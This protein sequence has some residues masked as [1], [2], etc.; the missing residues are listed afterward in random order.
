[1]G[2]LQRPQ[3]LT[4]GRPQVEEVPHF[5][6]PGPRGRP[7]HPERSIPRARAAVAAPRAALAAL[8][9]PARARR[10]GG[11]RVAA[12]DRAAGGDGAD[13]LDPHRT[14]LHPAPH[15]TQVA[16]APIPVVTLYDWIWWIGFSCKFQSDVPAQR[17]PTPDAS[18]P[19]PRP[20]RELGPWAR[21]TLHVFFNRPRLSQ[22]VLD[23]VQHFYLTGEPHPC[24]QPCP[25]LPRSAARARTV[26]GDACCRHRPSASP[27]P[28]TRGSSGAA[29]TTRR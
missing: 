1:M 8:A 4:L 5:P 26:V 25:T 7:T 29:T 19:L 27:F 24:P 12:L 15:P 14:Y 16:K 6:P 10:R 3:Q 20:Y 22:A 2:S 28:Q 9:P 21:Q 23:S 18:R 11:A 17:A 13:D